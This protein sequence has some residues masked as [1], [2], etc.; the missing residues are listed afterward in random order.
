MTPPREPG[1]TPM[2]GRYVA[3]LVLEAA[4]V[5]ALYLIGRVYQ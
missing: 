4:I 2:T 5:V 3:A 1:D